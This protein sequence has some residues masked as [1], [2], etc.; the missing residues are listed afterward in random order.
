MGGDADGVGEGGVRGDTEA[1]ATG[2]DRDCVAGCCG[3]N[4][5]P[6]IE[7]ASR[8]VLPVRSMLLLLAGVLL[9]LL[10]VAVVVLVVVDDV[11]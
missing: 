7:L 10:L 1:A 4:E 3:L 5:V 8:F 9:L 6:C 11:L 2:V